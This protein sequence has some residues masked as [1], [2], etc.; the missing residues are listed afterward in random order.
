[1]CDILVA[2]K[3]G[4]ECRKFGIALEK[5]QEIANLNL[6]SLPAGCLLLMLGHGVFCYKDQYMWGYD[7]LKENELKLQNQE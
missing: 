4:E 2:S 1:M 7:A 6:S 5:M 3:I